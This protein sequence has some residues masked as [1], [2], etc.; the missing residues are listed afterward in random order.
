MIQKLVNIFKIKLRIRELAKLFSVLQHEKLL[1]SGS[2]DP[3]LL[4][5][6]FFFLLSAPPA[7]YGSFQAR[8]QI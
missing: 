7:A 5:L 4:I 6:I 2:E 3:C 1:F 8:S